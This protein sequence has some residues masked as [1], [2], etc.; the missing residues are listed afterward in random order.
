M[1]NSTA[2][3]TLAIGENYLNQW[4]KLC[5]KNWEQYANKYGYDIICIDTPLDNSERAQKRSPAW[6]KCLVLSQNF[7]KKYE[8]IVWIDSDIL[9]NTSNAPCIVKDVPVEKVGAVNA[10]QFSTPEGITESMRRIIEVM[11]SDGAPITFGLTPQA[12]YAGY[13]LSPE[14]DKIVQSGVMVFSHQHRE[15]LEKI[16]YSYEDKGRP[17][18]DFEMRPVSYELIKAGCVYWID[19]R[20][21]VVWFTYKHLYYPFLI[22]VSQE[23]SL[24]KIFPSLEK[25]CL[26]SAYANSFFFHLA[27]GPPVK[28]EMALVDTEATSWRDIPRNLNV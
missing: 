8:R 18:W 4:E 21:N 15:I 12:Y 17:E 7:S 19:H 13:G 22:K 28:D 11:K 10:W 14:F 1:S 2:L 5:R 16:Y 20:F 24:E 3:V 26:S 25:L 27:G 9:I 23:K 6:Q